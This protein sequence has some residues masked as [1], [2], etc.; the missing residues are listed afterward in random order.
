[1]NTVK[2][3]GIS[4]EIVARGKSVFIELKYKY[5]YSLTEFQQNKLLEIQNKLF[6]KFSNNVINKITLS[7]VIYEFNK[8][9]EEIRIKNKYFPGDYQ[10]ELHNEMEE[11]KN[12]S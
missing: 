11:R 3:F 9:A 1:M 7:Q 8:F 2:L 12:L 4:F 5:N 10:A 6:N